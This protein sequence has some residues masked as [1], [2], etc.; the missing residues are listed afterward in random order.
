MRIS[1]IITLLICVFGLN[2]SAVAGKIPKLKF[3][4][5]VSVKIPEPS[6]ICL[7]PDKNS[8]YIVSDN[9]ILFE[10]DLE[11][12]IIRQSNLTGIDFEGVHTD[13]KY[14]YVVDETPRKIHVVDIETFERVRTVEFPYQGGRNKGYEAITFNKHKNVFLLITE[15]E[16][17]YIFEINKELT[18][19]VNEFRFEHRNASDISAATY[20]DNH[21][22]LLSD[23]GMTI[24]KCNPENY[25]V[26]AAWEINVLNP[27]GIAFLPDGSMVIAADDLERLYFFNNPEK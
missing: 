5:W 21:V 14:I 24:F 1:I 20:Y 10:T 22:W 19:R 3:N 26:V 18:A 4:R 11:G 6:D 8:F 7:S 16:P 12:N 25:E 23:E 15:K 27:E 13:G 17:V 2:Q 9:G